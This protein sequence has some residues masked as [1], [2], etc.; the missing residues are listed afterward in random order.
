MIGT[1]L[2]V[3]WYC[4]CWVCCLPGLTAEAGGTARAAAWGCW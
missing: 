2:L 1:I 4:C 3:I